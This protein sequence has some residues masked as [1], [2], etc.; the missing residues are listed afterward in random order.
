[1]KSYRAKKMRIAKLIAFNLLKT[2]ILKY[3]N[4]KSRFAE[5]VGFWTKLTEISNQFSVSIDTAI[6]CIDVSFNDNAGCT[7][8]C[9][10]D[11]Y[12]INDYYLGKEI[13]EKLGTYHSFLHLIRR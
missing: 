12:D 4:A 7:C 11:F 6:Y 9:G 5:K 2:D 8:G 13:L 10:G 1:M 3:R